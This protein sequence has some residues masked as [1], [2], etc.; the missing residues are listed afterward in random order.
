MDTDYGSY[1][2]YDGYYRPA[3]GYRSY[4]RPGVR[5]YGART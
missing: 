4:Y 3:Y 2:G 1:Y 5:F